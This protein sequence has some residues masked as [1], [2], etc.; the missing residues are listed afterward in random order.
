MAAKDLPEALL[1]PVENAVA[2]LYIQAELL[3]D[4]E[5][6]EAAPMQQETAPMQQEMT[7]IQQEMQ[8]ETDDEFAD[9]SLSE[10]APTGTHLAANN[11][12]TA[13]AP[14]PAK[15]AATM[16]TAPAPAKAAATEPLE[17]KGTATSRRRPRQGCGS[18]QACKEYVLR[19][20]GNQSVRWDGKEIVLD[21]D[22]LEELYDKAEL[23]PGRIVKLPWEGKNGK[24]VDWK[25]MIVSVPT[26]TEG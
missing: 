10:Q 22:W 25:V 16:T 14:A 2:D 20:K 18:K 26:S 7:P 24:S 19:F 15:A 23:C 8:Q 3:S 21:G 4:A 12:T 13:P 17:K 6:Q 5:Q 1:P 11:M 9:P